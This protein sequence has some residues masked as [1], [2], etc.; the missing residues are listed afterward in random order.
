MS[1]SDARRT[2][3]D[4]VHSDRAPEQL[5][6]YQAS[7]EV[8]LRLIR[9]VAADDDALIDVG[10]GSSTLVDALL[11]AG[12]TNLSVLDISPR[13]LDLARARLGS[14]GWAVTWIAAHATSVELPSS[15]RIWH[16]RAVFHFLIDHDDREA[17]LDRLRHRLLRGGWLILASFGPDGPERCSGLPV[18][19]Y[20]APTL[21]SLLGEGFRLEAVVPE[22]HTTPAGRSQS[23]LYCRFRRAS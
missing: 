1:R 14:A 10:G 22:V 15:Y 19:R 13:A 3:W 8:S 20:D 5:S 16:D 4:T 11:A 7:P 6:W 12:H 23:F 18:Q 17:Y 9:E 21:E 2:H